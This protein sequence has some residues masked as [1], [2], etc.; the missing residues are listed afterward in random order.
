MGIDYDVLDNGGPRQVFNQHKLRI[1]DISSRDIKHT[2]DR[3]LELILREEMHQPLKKFS[4]L[5]SIK[6]CGSKKRL[7]MGK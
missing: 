5:N 6:M 2:T 3:D 4:G 1:S 7:F